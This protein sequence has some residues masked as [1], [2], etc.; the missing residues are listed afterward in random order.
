VRQWIDQVLDVAAQRGLA[1]DVVATEGTEAL[2]PSPSEAALDAAYD[3]LA[4]SDLDG[5]ET[6][7]RQQLERDP[8]DYAAR[9]ALVQL[10]LVRRAAGHDEVALRQTLEAN[11][12]DIAANSALA[13]LELLNGQADVAFNRLIE[14]FR[15]LPAETRDD[16][17][18]RLLELFEAVD[19]AD[20]AVIK[21]RRDLANALY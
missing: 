8:G 4:R 3:A 7:L 21:A 20:P 17:R 12:D 9:A 11:P 2:P 16:A 15:R 19:P 1:D 6:I 14:L 5:A 10:G 13:D 18:T